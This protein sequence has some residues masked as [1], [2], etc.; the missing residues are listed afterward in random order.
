MTVLTNTDQT[1]IVEL[2]KYEFVIRFAE[3]I[4]KLAKV[5]E[6]GYTVHLLCPHKKEIASSDDFKALQNL[7]K[8]VMQ[9]TPIEQAIKI[10]IDY[11][12][13]AGVAIG[14]KLNTGVTFER[15]ATLRQEAYADFQRIFGPMEEF[16]LQ[17]AAQIAEQ[18][19]KK[20]KEGK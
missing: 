17:K 6:R 12:L 13:G 5:P 14:Q 8:S 3:P 1:T 11:G 10:G 18:E 9:K 19:L 16:D 15:F 4:M 2:T 20:L 7:I